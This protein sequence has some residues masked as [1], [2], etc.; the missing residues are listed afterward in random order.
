[1]EG[2]RTTLED[3]DRCEEQ[4]HALIHGPAWKPVGV[5][6]QAD[7]SIRELH[8]RLTDLLARTVTSEV[9]SHFAANQ[10][11]SDWVRDGLALH[12][13]RDT[14]LFCESPVGKERRHRLER[15]FDESY[16][17][18]QN[19]IGALEQEIGRLRQQFGGLTTELPAGEQLFE[20]LRERYGDVV[21]K[22]RSGTDDLL[23]SLDRFEQVLGEKKGAM[24]TALAVPADVETLTVDLGELHG[25]LDEH[26]RGT[27][28]RDL[29]RSQAA[30]REFQRM[31]HGIEETWRDHHS[32]EESLGTEI[33]NL[34][35]FLAECQEVLRETPREGPDPH[36][37]LS[38]LNL[39]IRSLLQHGEL[40]FDYEDG[41][42]QVMRSG[43][44]AR[45]LSEGEKTAIALLYFLQSLV[46]HGREL[47]QTIVVV[48]DPVSSL[49]DHL[50]FGVYSTLA[51]RLEP[52]KLCRQLFVLTHSTQF[53]RHWSRDLL[54]GAPDVR[55]AHATLHFMK[56]VDRPDR[57]GSGAVRQ[58]VLYPVDLESPVAT[59]LGAEYLLLFY[60]A[61]WDLLEATQGTCVDADIRLATSTPNDAR[62]LLEYFLQFKA[63]KQATD[64]TGAV[65]YVLRKDLVRADRLVNF[66][67]PHCHS[68]FGEGDGQIL[69]F[70]GREI[71]SDVFALM[72]E[73]DRDHFGGV[74]HRLGLTKYMDRLVSV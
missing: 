74:C 38:L 55:R 32:Q 17:R 10:A 44:P 70:R 50:M 31:L 6:A 68:T 71:I 3:L 61:A 63:P 26:D 29:D 16:T 19:D 22:V 21:K 62:R 7:P 20:H 2:H 52:G 53:L 35:D 37:F 9:I 60:R 57:D 12:A 49:D 58:P 5:T 66:L 72:R 40:T 56:S 41:H 73:C 64:L 45:N 25:I 59:I 23:L 47:K 39:D 4:D 34:Q 33:K 14:C 36:H 1:M 8:G 65:T 15:H 43:S 18:L 11:H 13:D 24:F 54:R 28:T 67:H 48:D 51:T 69:D 30:E 46:E 42:Y 27:R